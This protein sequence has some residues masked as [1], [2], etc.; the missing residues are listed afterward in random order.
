MDFPI[1]LAAYRPV[2]LDP[3]RAELSGAERTQLRAN[4]AL[5]RDAIVFFTAVADAKGLG[6][7]TGGPY[8]IVPELLLADGFM[9][10][11]DLLVPV[12]FD[13]AGHR[14]AIQYLMSVLHGHMPAERLLHYREAGSKL[15]GH[16]ERG[17]TPGVEFSSGR[18]GHL[19]AYCNGVARANPG[20]SVIVFGSDGSQLEGTDAE[21]ARFAVANKL[22]LKL[23]ID[24]N[25][26]TITGRPS[27]YMPGFDLARTLGGHGVAVDTGDGE[28]LDA[29]YRRMRK[30]LTTPGPVALVNTRKMAPGL[31]GVE[32][33]AKAHDVVKVPVAIEYLAA[34]GHTRA[35]EVI[36]AQKKPAR[37]TGYRGIATVAW[38]SNRDEF[39]KAVVDL[40][41]PLDAKERARRVLVVD[42]DLAGSCGLSHI[43]AAFPEVYVEGGPMERNNFSVAAGFGSEPGRQGIFATFSA[44][45]EM[46][47]SEITMARL[48]DA[49]V[50]AHFSHA[51]VDDMA[52]NTCH[53]G[54]NN[55]FAA[56]GLAEGDLTRLYF[57]A[58]ARQMRAVVARVFD[59]PGLRFVFSTRS[60]APEIRDAKGAPRFGDGYVF[61]PGRDE[62]IRDG[63]AGWVVSYGEMLFRALDAVERVR[64]AG[65]DVGLVAKPTLNVPD[66][67]MLA[68]IGPSPFVLLVESQNRATGLG[69]RFGTWLLERGLAPCYEHLGT[70]RPGDGG[71]WEHMAHQGLDPDS[72]ADRIRALAARARRNAP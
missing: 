63:K 24:A 46:V 54:L 39:G 50:L 12:H 11:T 17:L 56:N 47:V 25:D 19:W 51:G 3:K 20:K 34:R 72:I 13:E 33:S 44:F 37:P 45:L 32:G 21:A 38:G 1:D 61:E 14:V 57:P 40:L 9:R 8:D 62:V 7:H 22:D 53:F 6:G 10:G 15:P 67:A 55:F 58:D 31:K 71:L 27:E 16:P 5:C 2:P 69:V 42:N 43:Q 4:V 30:A 18:L 28:D 66:D 23:V 60:P 59:D 35:I 64:E 68:R 70:T 65:L 48:N 36:E 41:K 49:R 52:D 29:L 26:I